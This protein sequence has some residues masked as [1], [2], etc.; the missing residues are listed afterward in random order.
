MKRC[1]DCGTQV[2]DNAIFCPQCGKNLAISGQDPMTV[3]GRIDALVSSANRNQ[4]LKKW[5]EAIADAA[6]AFSLNPQKADTATLIASIYEQR[7]MLDEAAIWYRSA[8]QLNPNS[9]TDQVL[10]DHVLERSMK[11]NKPETAK[12]IPLI[13]AV[14][15]GI[16]VMFIL[17]SLSQKSK[18]TVVK[19][20]TTPTTLPSSPTPPLIPRTN[21]DIAQPQPTQVDPQANTATLPA[22]PTWKTAGE[23]EI[24]NRIAESEYMQ[25]TGANVDDVTIDP[26]GPT[27]TIT[28]SLAYSSKITKNWIQWSSAMAA[29]AAF[30]SQKMI[31]SATV[32]CIQTGAEGGNQLVFVGDITRASAVSIPK[33][34]NMVQLSAAFGRTWWR[35]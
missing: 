26:N 3:T 9:V 34:Y 7:G 30:Q 16:L 4:N 15:A 17:V 20:D 14:I 35:E 25:K 32:R 1:Y 22:T 31:N 11:K 33:N 18:K 24:K 5:D 23:V 28:I 12:N 2:D 6:E 10:L 29:F 8:L 19:P 21:R 27:A 13:L